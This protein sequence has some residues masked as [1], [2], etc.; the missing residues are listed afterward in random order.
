MAEVD[1]KGEFMPGFALIL[2]KR[3]MELRDETKE[4]YDVARMIEVFA[5]RC[6]SDRALFSCF[7]RHLHR[8]LGMFE[9]VDFVRFARGLAATEYRDDRVPHALAKWACKR[10]AEFSAYDWDGFVDSLAVL[11]VP[12][13]RLAKLRQFGPAMVPLEG[14]SHS[15]GPRG[16]LAIVAV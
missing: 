15:V 9:P 6:P 3:L 11:G 7:C 1:H 10:Y 13:A 5:R 8:H 4:R 16:D 14:A 12:E 2:T